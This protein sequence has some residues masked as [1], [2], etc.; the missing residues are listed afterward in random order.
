VK[1][2]LYRNQDVEPYP[3]DGMGELRQLTDGQLIAKARMARLEFSV[4]P[5]SL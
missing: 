3:S 5:R 2:I 1:G 4:R